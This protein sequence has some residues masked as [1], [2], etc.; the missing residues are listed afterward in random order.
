MDAFILS[1][2]KTEKYSKE[3]FEYKLSAGKFAI[4]IIGC[5]SNSVDKKV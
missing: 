5:L 2:D 4:R 3:N 1:L